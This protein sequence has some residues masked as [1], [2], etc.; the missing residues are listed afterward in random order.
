VGDRVSFRLGQ[1]TAVGTVV[2]DSGNLAPGGKQ[3]V[4]VEVVVDET[5]HAAFDVAIDEATRLE[6]A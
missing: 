5:Y 2:E 3:L 1:K 4:R 6:A